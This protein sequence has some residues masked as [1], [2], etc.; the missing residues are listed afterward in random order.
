MKHSASAKAFLA[1]LDSELAANAAA[2]GRELGWSAN[3]VKIR[4]MVA[5]ELTRIDDL[6]AAYDKSPDDIKLRLALNTELRLS[7][8][9]VGRLLRQISTEPSAPQS[10]VSQQNQRA[11]NIRWQRERDRDL[12]V[13][14]G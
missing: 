3:E 4:E 13:V 9:T 11:A 6:Q 8:S 5:N 2:S 14:N 7:E 1:E 12:G 10:R